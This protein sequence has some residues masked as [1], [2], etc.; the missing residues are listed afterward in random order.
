MKKVI[1]WIFFVGGILVPIMAIILAIVDPND[2]IVLTFG[3]IGKS[4][5]ATVIAVPWGAHLI[6][7]AREE[8]MARIAREIRQLAAE[9][10]AEW[11]QETNGS[12][13]MPDWL[14][15]KGYLDKYKSVIDLDGNE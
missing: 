3:L 7:Q 9:K 15:Q 11:L 1:G 13:P 5:I 2:N 8:D 14:K 6:K 4:L 10:E 12:I